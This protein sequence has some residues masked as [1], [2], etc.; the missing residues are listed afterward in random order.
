MPKPKKLFEKFAG[1]TRMGDLFVLPVEA[2]IRM[3]VDVQMERRAIVAA[4]V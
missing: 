4:G 3:T 2:L 1:P